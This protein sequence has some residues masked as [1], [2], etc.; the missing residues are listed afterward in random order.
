MNG[1]IGDGRLLAPQIDE[2]QSVLQDGLQLAPGAQ[3]A[4]QME[5]GLLVQGAT[6]AVEGLF[7]PGVTEVVEPGGFLGRLA[8]Q[9]GLEGDEGATVITDAFAQ[10]DELLGP[11]AT[12]RR[13]P[14]HETQP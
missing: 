8:E 9:V 2:A 3:T 4:G 10:G 11:R 7:P 13:G 14:R 12:R 1:F 5:L 6:E